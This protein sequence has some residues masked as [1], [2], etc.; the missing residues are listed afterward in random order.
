[1]IPLLK[2]HKQRITTYRASQ[3]TSSTASAIKRSLFD[4]ETGTEIDFSMEN[5]EKLTRPASALPDY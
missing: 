2:H 4:W 1:M 5:F 3:R